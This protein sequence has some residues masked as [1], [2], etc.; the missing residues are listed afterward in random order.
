MPWPTPQDYR[1]AMQHLPGALADPELQAGRAEEDCW[2]LPRVISGGF[3]SVYKVITPSKTWAVRCFLKEFQDQEQRYDAISKELSR[4]NLPFTVQF[5]FMRQGI[6]VRGRWYPALKME[7]VEGETL[8]QYVAKNLHSPPV[9]RSLSAEIEQ[10]A[11]ALDGAG[12]A[13][14]DLQHGNILIVKGKPKLI[15]YDGMYVPALRGWGSHEV[16]HPNYQHPARTENDFGPGLDHFS[17]WVICLSLRALSINP[18]LW[19]QFQGGDECLLLRRQ[20]FANPVQSGVL[21]ELERLPALKSLVGEFRS[22]LGRGPLQVPLPSSPPPS[23][24]PLPPWMSVEVSQVS[25]IHSVSLP[26]SSS[27]LP[28]WMSAAAGQVSPI[29]SIPPPPSPPPSSSSPLHPH[30]QRQDRPQTPPPPLPFISASEAAEWEGEEVTVRVVV[31]STY[32]GFDWAFMINSEEDFRRPKN[33]TVVIEKRSA[34][35]KYKAIGISDLSQYFKK[36][37]VLLVTGKIE[38]YQDMRSHRVRY[39]IWVKDPEQIQRQP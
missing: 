23:P 26:P 17:V 37:T 35:V 10:M 18:Q 21:R 32:D 19:A 29:H 38:K 30:G 6:R 22:L 34:G 33:F 4:A 27:L 12:I 39:Q 16:G 24:S 3:A 36:D 2:G 5:V 13:H 7:W 25:P 14:G 31:K 15:D 1:E 11:Y 9:L 20:D 8:G 28:S